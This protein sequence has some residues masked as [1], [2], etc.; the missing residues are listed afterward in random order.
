ME[1]SRL[2]V[3]LAVGL[4]VAAGF[5]ALASVLDVPALRFAAV[6]A[7]V[8]VLVAREVWTWRGAGRAWVGMLLAVIAVAAVAFVVE[9][10]PA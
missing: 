9:R 5:L 1:T 2:L 3:A 8:G 6:A 4:A 7:I 10:L